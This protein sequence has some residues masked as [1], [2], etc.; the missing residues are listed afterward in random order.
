MTCA[1][2]PLLQLGDLQ[3]DDVRRK[4][5]VRSGGAALGLGLAVGLYLAQLLASLSF[6]SFQPFRLSQPASSTWGLRVSRGIW[7]HWTQS[8]WGLCLWWLLG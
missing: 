8:A 3:V 2:E 4:P 1:V 7:G 6:Q 5:A